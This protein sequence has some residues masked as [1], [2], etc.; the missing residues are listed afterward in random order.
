[1]N[2]QKFEQRRIRLIGQEQVERAIAV[3]RNAPV[4]AKKPLEMLLRE[5]VK[6]RK[7]DQNALMWAGPLKD[8]AEQAWIEERQHSAAIWHEYFKRHL[9][10]DQY[11]PE[12]CRNENYVKWDFDP[13][14]DRVLAASSTDL[15]VKGFA[16]Y[17]EQIH[18]FGASLGVQ[19]SANPRD[20]A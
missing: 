8:I 18:A 13:G 15:T 17:I 16:E 1:M 14:G 9:L 19:Y 5:E 2:R 6:A 12:L 20:V 4:D 11:D 7:P 3:L 10:P